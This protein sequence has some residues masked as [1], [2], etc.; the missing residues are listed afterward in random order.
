MKFL[1][2]LAKAVSAALGHA[3]KL[4]GDTAKFVR[5]ELAR[6]ARVNAEAAARR[7]E[8][9]RVVDELLGDE[10]EAGFLGSRRRGWLR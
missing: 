6:R 1:R 5:E 2:R 3:P 4:S 8:C 9:A 10:G 7:S